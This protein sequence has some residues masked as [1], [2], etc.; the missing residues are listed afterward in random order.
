MTNALPPLYNGHAP[1]TLQQLFR[2]A[3]YAFEEWDTGLTEP[4]VTF[5]GRITPISLVFEAMRECNDIVP[6]NISIAI[7]Q[8]L[9]KPWEGEGPLDQMS[10]STA[11]R[12]MRVL[13]RKRLL[14]DGAAEIVTV[15]K[16]TAERIPSE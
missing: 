5:E 15:S 6:M 9:T 2:E 12:I 8:R 14:A 16:L 4:L 1:I 7:T 13:V 10:F 3:L 11:A